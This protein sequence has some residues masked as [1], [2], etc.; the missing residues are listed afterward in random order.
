MLVCRV[1]LHHAV[2]G[3]V[4]ARAGSVKAMRAAVPRRSF[5]SWDGVYAWMVANPDIAALSAVTATTMVLLRRQERRTREL[6]FELRAASAVADVQARREL[7][8]QQASARLSASLEEALERQQK[9]RASLAAESTKNAQLAKREQELTQTHSQVQTLLRAA[10]H[11]EQQLHASIVHRGKLGEVA[12]ERLLLE[13]KES[14]LAEA[15][16]LQPDCNGKRPDAVVY[17]AGGRTL[18]VDSKAPQPPS[19]LLET[20]DDGARQRYVD[21]LKRHIS[22]LGSKRYTAELPDPLPRTWLLLPGD[23]YLSAAYADGVDLLGLHAYANERDV[24]LVGPAG[25]RSMLQMWG[26]LQS[27]RDAERRLQDESV[28]Q[29]LGRI[30]TEWTGKV[31]PLSKQLG[32]QLDKSINEYNKM[33]K[34]ITVFDECLRHPEV[35]GLRNA[36]KTDLPKIVGGAAKST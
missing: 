29:S 9:L 33:A 3:S 36:R 25:L 19:E 31:L 8:L 12:L 22:L 34:I 18:A 26:L 35:L 11:R 14:G 5:M 1:M 7:E 28:Q 21:T 30:Q 20:G 27:E 17:L 4:K 10:T 13:A 2:T 24:A 15:F 6:D 23:G 16:E 32:K